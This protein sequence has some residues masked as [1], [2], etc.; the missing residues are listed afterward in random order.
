MVELLKP[1]RGGFLRPFGC[2]RF[3]KGLLLGNG[4]YGSPHIDPATGA[5]QADIFYRYMPS[6]LR[7]IAQ[8]MATTEDKREARHVRRCFHFTENPRPL[9]PGKDKA[10]HGVG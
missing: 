1:G 2:G 7:A 4:P 5:L 3:I 8:A 9:Y 6:F 10:L